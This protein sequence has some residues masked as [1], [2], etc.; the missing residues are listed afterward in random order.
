MNLLD[1]PFINGY[2]SLIAGYGLMILGIAGILVTG[3]DFLSALGN[4][5]TGS[6]SIQDCVQQ[7]QIT[8]ISLFA[9]FEGLGKIGIAHKLEKQN[10]SR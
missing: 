8:F 2:K 5:L 9:S 1:I 3:A 4:C 7:S 6:L 10:A